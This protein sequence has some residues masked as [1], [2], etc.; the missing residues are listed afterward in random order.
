MKTFII[1]GVVCS[2]LLADCYYFS[3][4]EPR[5]Y[6]DLEQCKQEAMVLGKSLQEEYNKKNFPAI[7]NI[8]CEEASKWQ[9]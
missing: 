2:P 1:L 7:I 4:L 8:K 9:V 6:K 5:E 3:P